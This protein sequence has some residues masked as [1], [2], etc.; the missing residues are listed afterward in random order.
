MVLTICKRCKRKIKNKDGTGYGDTCMKKVL[1]AK[2]KH[3]NLLD[4]FEC[5]SYE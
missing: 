2:S 5:D 4:D 3:K 1:A